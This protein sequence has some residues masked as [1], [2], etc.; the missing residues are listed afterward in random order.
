MSLTVHD[1]LAARDGAAAVIHSRLRQHLHGIPDSGNDVLAYRAGELE[2]AVAELLRVFAADESA[3]AEVLTGAV[4][5][6]EVRTA[7]PPAAVVDAVTGDSGS[8]ARL[9]EIAARTADVTTPPGAR[10]DAHTE[11]CRWARTVATEHGVAA[12]DVYN[13]AV[14]IARWA[15]IQPRDVYRA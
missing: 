4:R 8:A 6:I 11:A 1:V 13:V 14:D 5:M 9:R 12:A 2:A 10:A 7:A 15:A 3:A